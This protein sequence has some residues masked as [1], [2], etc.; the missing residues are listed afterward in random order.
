V[1]DLVL[2]LVVAACFLALAAPRLAEPPV[3]VFDEVFHARSGTLLARGLPPSEVSHPP[4]LKDLV[5]VSTRLLAPAFEPRG[6]RWEPGAGASY[7]REAVVAWRLPSLLAGAWAVGVAYALGR[8]LGGRAVGL[9]AACLLAAD[10]CFWVHARLAQ[11]NALEAASVLTA[12]SCAW[13]FGSGGRLPWLFAA[14][15]AIGLAL[16]TRWSALAPW[17]A[18]GAWLGW[19]ACGERRALVHLAAAWLA[20]PFMVYLGSWL[21]VLATHHPDGLLG[22]GTALVEAQAAAWGYHA[23]LAEVHAYQSA[24]WSWPLM[25]RPVWY[26]FSWHGGQVTAVWAIGNAVLWWVSV[27]ALLAAL[28]AGIRGATGLGLVGAVGLV[29]WLAWAAAPRSLTFMHYYLTTVPLAA[30][31]IAAIGAAW[32]QGRGLVG[33]GP[34]PLGP[35]VARF[36]VVAGAVAAVAWRV[37]YHPVL[38]AVPITRAELLQRV[39]FGPAWL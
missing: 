1:L 25:A 5:A 8:S 6:H 17:L 37:W 27:P 21:P 22:W 12:V 34:P 26:H 32:W 14:G 35:A 2:A 38:A 28:R 20:L 15:G 39:W 7:P 9:A 24:W 18:M 23:R 11:T 10:G 31:A 13:R 33:H 3:P 30:V 16:A 19:R 36:V 29:A 4:L